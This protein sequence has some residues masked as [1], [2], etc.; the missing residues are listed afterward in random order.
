M[1]DT[2]AATNGLHLKKTVRADG[3]AL[4]GIFRDADTVRYTN[5]RQFDDLD[6]LNGFLD[7]FLSIGQGQPLQY[8]PYSIYLGDQLVGL[9][10]AQQKDLDE[11]SSE[12]WYILH[13]DHWGKGLAKRAVETLIRECRS[14]PRLKSLY[15]EAVSSNAGSWRI[16][17]KLGFMQTGE[18]KDGFKKGD[19]V[20]DLRSYILNCKASTI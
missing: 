7:R 17:E 18:V 4:L 20:E 8:G 14:N 2:P 12:L 13:K 11:G 16:L 19:L 15:A 5:F 9:C 3:P 6:S 10:G 1:K